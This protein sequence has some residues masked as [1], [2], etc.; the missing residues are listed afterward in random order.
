MNINPLL[1]QQ[2]IT[3]INSTKQHNASI[4][5][6]STINFGCSKSER[7][8]RLLDDTIDALITGSELNIANRLRFRSVLREALP[9]IIRPENYINKGRDSKVY[10]ISDKYVAKIQRH[11]YADN[12]IGSFDRVHLPDKKFRQLDFYY[13]EPVAT[14]GKVEIL[15]NATPSS[16]HMFCGTK[17]HSNGIVLD[18]ERASYI[19]E[20][21]PICSEVPQG[22]Y[23]NLAANLNRL[24]GITRRNIK[25]Q[26][27][28]YTPDIVNPNNLL[29]SDN[30]FV[31]VDRL[32]AVP[33]KKPNSIFT[34]L[35][36]LFLRL[37]PETDASFERINKDSN[38]VVNFRKKIFKKS[39]IA[40]EKTGL[41]LDSPYKYEHDEW[42]LNTVLK[43][44]N[45]LDNVRVMRDRGIPVEERIHEI[46]QRLAD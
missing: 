30:R 6:K 40:A 44:D 29:I 5:P 8:L 11:H 36:P 32:D 7:A 20:F 46:S 3:Q 15:K 17:Y 38:D 9:A 33:F 22:S 26:Q 21:L 39:L 18:S 37:T 31:L 43:D 23:D 2:N 41:P 13:G 28:T 1:N 35:E 14:L 24:N 10:R 34:M 12:S 4:V 42:V 19:H 45:I 27:E 16:N 25:L